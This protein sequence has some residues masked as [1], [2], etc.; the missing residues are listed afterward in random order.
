[1]TEPPT[2][3]LMDKAALPPEHQ[4]HTGASPETPRAVMVLHYVG[5]RA[6]TI[7]DILCFTEKTL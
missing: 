6:Q 3:E 7:E 4:S 1:M 5:V 2:K